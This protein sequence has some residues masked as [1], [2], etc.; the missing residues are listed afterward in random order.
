MTSKIPISVL[1]T[2]YNR[3]RYLAECLQ[4]I[5]DSTFSQFEVVVVDDRSSDSS[6]QIASEFASRD[7]RIRVFQNPVNLGDYPNRNR[8]AQL[9]RGTWLKYV[10]S[11]DRIVPA[12]LENMLNAAGRFPDTGL[13]LSYPRPENQPR[14]LCMSPQTAWREHFIGRQGFFCSGPLLSLIRTECFRAVGGFRPAARNMGDTILWLELCRRWP[15]VITEPDLTFWRQ[16]DEQEFQLVRNG[17]W[18]NTHTHCKLTEVLLRDFLVGDCPLNN[19]DRRAVRRKLQWNNFRRLAWHLKHLRLRQ[20]GAEMLWTLRSLLG[21]HTGC[22]R[23]VLIA[24]TH[25][26]FAVTDNTQGAEI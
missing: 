19:F 4:S 8:A 17:G 18:D 7:P 20:L 10:D 6:L 23:K 25:A 24:E 1:V 12:C 9:A 15:L 5:L 14:P 3:Q 21:W 2:V 16:H 11:D 26:A 13:V 22:V